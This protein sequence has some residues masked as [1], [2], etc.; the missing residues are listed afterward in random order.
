MKEKDAREIL[1]E[2]LSVLKEN[3]VI[4]NIYVNIDTNNG[5]INFVDTHDKN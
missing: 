2:V 4:L 1:L 3:D 5:A